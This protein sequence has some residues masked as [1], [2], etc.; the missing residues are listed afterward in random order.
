MTP[1]NQLRVVFFSHWMNGNRGKWKELEMVEGEEYF[2]FIK[3][4]NEWDLSRLSW[5]HFLFCTQAGRCHCHGVKDH[6]S[7]WEEVE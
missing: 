6:E 4:E 5:F 1:V 2:N 7:A 3:L